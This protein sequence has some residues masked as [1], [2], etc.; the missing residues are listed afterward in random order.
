MVVIKSGG[1][2]ISALDIEREML[3]LDY[4]AEASV[5]GVADEEFGQRVAAVLVLRDT[6]QKLSLSKLRND[7]RSMMSSYKLP[8]MLYLAEDLVK[9]A[10][11][12]VQKKALGKEVF[13]S[14][15]YVQDIQI[16]APTRNSIRSRL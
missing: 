13:E 2:K 5:I 16:F 10:S 15:K 9:T 1:Y 11:G 12:K 6:T 4:I 8:T 14:G 7:L 3:T